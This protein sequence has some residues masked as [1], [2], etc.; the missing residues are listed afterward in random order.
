MPPV[1]SQNEREDDQNT[2]KAK[3]LNFFKIEESKFKT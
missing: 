3:A 2:V 1:K